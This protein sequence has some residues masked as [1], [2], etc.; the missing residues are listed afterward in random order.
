[1]YRKIDQRLKERLKQGMV[2]EVKNLLKKGVSHKRL[3]SLGLE[4]RFVSL[5]LQN[6]LAYQ[7]MTEKLKNAIYQYAK[8]QMTWFK[9]NKKI[10]W[11][12]SED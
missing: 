9:R 1:L 4:Y 5:Y 10:N 8:K 3:Q 6:K 2:Q 12:N 7:E 11:I